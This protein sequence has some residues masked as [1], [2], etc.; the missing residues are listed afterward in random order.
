MQHTSFAGDT[1]HISS[2]N[3][4][5]GWMLFRSLTTKREWPAKPWK[6]TAYLRIILESQ[7]SKSKLGRFVYQIWITS[8]KA[9]ALSATCEVVH[10][11]PGI[12]NIR[13]MV[14]I[15]LSTVEVR[16]LNAVR[17]ERQTL[18]K[19]STSKL[20]AND[21]GSAL[22]VPKAPR[23]SWQRSLGY[24]RLWIALRKMLVLYHNTQSS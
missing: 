11:Q 8:W 4:V 22:V 1:N 17:L 5:N 20:A 6:W 12:L 7:E 13:D 14:P 24:W 19:S 15:E 2:W 10:F 16:L 23:T 21:M 18:S 3:F 9:W